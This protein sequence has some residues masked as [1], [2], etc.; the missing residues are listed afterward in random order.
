[1]YVVSKMLF[2]VTDLCWFVNNGPS[3][4]GSPCKEPTQEQFGVS[5]LT[6]FTSGRP[7]AD[8]AAQCRHPDDPN[9]V[10]CKYQI[11][12]SLTFAFSQPTGQLVFL[13]L[14]LWTDLSPQGQNVLLRQ[15]SGSQLRTY[16]LQ[17]HMF[18]KDRCSM[19]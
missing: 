14:I 8:L 3:H 11:R 4:S 10:C 12:F 6:S 18:R 2:R 5:T 1:M 19:C 17:Q 16:G 13:P 9:A 7:K 15:S